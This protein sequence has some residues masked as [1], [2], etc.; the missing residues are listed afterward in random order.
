MVLESCS[1][2]RAGS[3]SDSRITKW[4]GHRC[5][6]SESREPTSL[7]TMTPEVGSTLNHHIEVNRRSVMSPDVS[8]G[9]YPMPLLLRRNTNSGPDCR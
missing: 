2:I 4:W 8:P 6:N 3:S 5:I 9:N 1:S 7:A